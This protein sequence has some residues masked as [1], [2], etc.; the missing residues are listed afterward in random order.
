VPLIVQ[1]GTLIGNATVL[2]VAR[3]SR[4]CTP[5]FP[6]L[7]SP[8]VVSSRT[9]SFGDI[10]MSRRYNNTG[11][12][13]VDD[14]FF[15]LFRFTVKPFVV[16][17]LASLFESDDALPGTC[18]VQNSS[19]EADE[20]ALIEGFAG[21][22]AGSRVTIQGPNGNAMVPAGDEAVLSG[23]GPFLTAGNYTA[24]ATGGADV[25]PI[26][27]TLTI[28]ALPTLVSPASGTRLT[29]TRADGLTVT[30]QGGS[31]GTVQVTLTS[32]ANLGEV[33]AS[34]VAP[35]GAGTLTIPPYVLLAL[36]TGTQGDF[37]F[38]FRVQ[39]SFSATGL[40]AGSLQASI[41]REGLFGVTLR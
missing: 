12:G 20:D 26:N 33:T 17:F 31:T 29:V 23:A 25:G 41:L 11:N 24:A 34:C 35:A 16:P 8:Q 7:T 38:R 18:T 32:F 4:N 14:A 40:D 2:P 21:L 3:G 28:P 36:P 30:W 9:I 6:A 1:I 27:A 13:F 37:R 5:A 19:N 22:N 39:T 10:G 15:E